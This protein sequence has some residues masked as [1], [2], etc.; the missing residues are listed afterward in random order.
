VLSKKGLEPDRKVEMAR[1]G[2][3][4]LA[5][6]A[7][8][9][10]NDLYATKKD[11]DDQSF[12]NGYQKGQGIFYEAD[13]Y[14]R[15]KEPDKAQAAVTQL[16]QE[17]LALK[18]QVAGKDDRRKSCAALES[19]YWG[20]MA[21]LGELQGR[22]LDAMAYYQSALL[23]R[24]DSGQIPVAG[25]KDELGRHRPRLENVVWPPR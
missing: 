17:V 19:S 11:I 8:R 25:E 23:A 20:A 14:V 22:K 9:P 3:D 13:G 10:P 4:E 7:A 24:L 1:K 12:Y 15:L 2:L 6:E 16:D 5:A 18:S 21:R